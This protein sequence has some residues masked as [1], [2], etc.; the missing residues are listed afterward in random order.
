MSFS[1]LFQPEAEEQLAALERA[2]KRKHRKVLSCLGKLETNPKHPVLHSH[3]YEALDDVDG[4]R[5]WES[6]AE[7]KTPAAFRVFW[8]YG[9]ERGEITVVAITKHP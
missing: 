8:H 6:Y 3:R 5:I 9:P 1:L 2:D 7:N 4:E